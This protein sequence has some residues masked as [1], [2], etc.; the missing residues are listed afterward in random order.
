MKVFIA[1]LRGVNVGGHNKLPM[2]E[3]RSE[4]DI[5][6]FKKVKT[7]IQS[8]NVIFHS[9]LQNTKEIESNVASVINSKFGLDIPVIVKTSEDIQLLLDLCPFIPEQKEKSYFILLSAIP[10]HALV[11]EV[12]NITFE[13]EYFEIIKDCLYFFA[14]KGYGRTKF[15]M[16]TFEKKLNVIGTARN[17]NTMLK[18][19]G[20]S[21]SE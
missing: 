7:Y 3:L 1:L 18:L 4:L 9:E 6:G 19:L 21:S 17:Y 5:A 16:K 13:N 12:S 11:D 15:K 8:G 20:L 10:D 14:S 2:A